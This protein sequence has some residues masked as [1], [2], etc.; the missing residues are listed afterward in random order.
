MAQRKM[1][2]LM[3]GPTAEVKGGI[4]SVVKVILSREME[5]INLTHVGTYTETHFLNKYPFFL[6][7][8]GQI[9]KMVRK[10]KPDLVHI[11]FS[12]H[13]S[14]FRKST[15]GAYFYSKNIPYIAHCHSSSLREFYA[16]LPG[17]FQKRMQRFLMNSEAVVVLSNSWESY[18][19]ETLG[20]PR[21]KIIVLP[22][23]VI[24][25]EAVPA[26]NYSTGTLNLLFLG[27]IGHRKGSFVLIEALQKAVQKL[28]KRS[29]HIRMAGNGEVEK[30]IEMAKELGVS[31][32][33]HITNWLRG[34]ELQQAFRDA[35]AFVLPSFNEGL[36][37]AILEA[38]GWGLP[39]ISTPVGGIPEVIIDGHNGLLVAPGDAD[40]LCDALCRMALA[41]ESNEVLSRNARR[42]AEPYRVETYLQKLRELYFDMAAIEPETKLKA[43][44]Y[45]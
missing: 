21:E 11:H 12:S 15:L 16:K 20:I 25:P 9:R 42:S 37:M 14:F 1:N 40:A 38:L 39:V 3:V 19:V 24:L 30:A 44:T 33:I 22:N 8:F 28:G 36:P 17:I 32:L 41:G 2:V 23:P 34:D 18:F 43:E 31:D 4:T 6:K 5:D 26:R 13:G 10:E 7:K 29:I 35:H 45:L 27:L